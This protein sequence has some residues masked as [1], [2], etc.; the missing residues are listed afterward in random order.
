[1]QRLSQE[2]LE[3][4][5]KESYK[6]LISLKTKRGNNGGP[7]ADD[8]PNEK[9]ENLKK[10]YAK[11]TSQLL[12]QQNGGGNMLQTG[13][14]QD[15][16]QSVQQSIQ[17]KLNR[18]FQDLNSGSAHVANTMTF[19]DSFW[20]PKKPAYHHMRDERNQILYLLQSGHNN[21]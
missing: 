16:S 13:P 9:K 20:K 17:D 8:E 3:K 11:F 19:N 5:L 18:S 4:V 7:N 12:L 14:S 2:E 1:M 10:K 21:N 15:Q 6:T